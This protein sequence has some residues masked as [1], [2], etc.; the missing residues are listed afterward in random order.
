VAQPIWL[1][2]VRRLLREAI[3]FDQQDPR[4]RAAL[5]DSVLDFVR[6]ALAPPLEQA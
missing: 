5:V 4:M 1:T 3:G 6:A 2:R